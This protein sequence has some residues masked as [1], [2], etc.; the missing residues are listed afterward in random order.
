MKMRTR[1]E[2]FPLQNYAIRRFFRIAPLFYVGI[3][4]YLLVNGVA[5]SQW[6]PEGIR[7][8]HILST[9]TFVNGLY[10][11]TINSVVPGGWSI[12]VE[13]S[14]YVL[15]P[16]L[17]RWITT[18]PRAIAATLGAVFFSLIMHSL[19]QRFYIA[20]SPAYNFIFSF[21][22]ESWLPAQLPI[23]LLGFVLFFILQGNVAVGADPNKAQRQKT[24]LLLLTIST[25]ITLTFMVSPDLKYLPDVIMYGVAFLLLA[26][27]LALYPWLPLVNPIIGY[28][29]KVSFSCYL[30]HFFVVF[31][32]IPRL[33]DSGLIAGLVTI[34]LVKLAV[35]YGLG[36]A[37]TVLLATLTFNLIEMPGMNLGKI[38][39]KRHEASATSAQQ[40]A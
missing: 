25:Y 6:V 17:V 4:F 38:L 35:F 11:T 30:V 40:S 27:G 31:T 7:W 5:P 33:L 19:G 2:A 1:Q 28:I 36:V 10:P 24:S 39:I 15:V 13:M 8:Y 22:L 20:P 29:G 21:F 9:A 32:I 34:P 3:L 26:W 37:L 12:A 23:F 16:T 14:F 18:L